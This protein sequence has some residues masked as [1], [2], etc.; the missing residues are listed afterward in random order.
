MQ[1]NVQYN[2]NGKLQTKKE[3][4]N[5]LNLDVTAMFAFVSNMTCEKCS[6]TFSQTILNDQARQEKLKSTKDILDV[7][8]HGQLN[9]ELYVY[10]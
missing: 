1:I 3:E 10:I 2:G 6:P 5:K 7:L 8:F 4:I 9:R